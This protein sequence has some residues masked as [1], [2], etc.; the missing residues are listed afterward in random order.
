MPKRKLT[1]KRIAQLAK[2]EAAGAAAREHAAEIGFSHPTGK[3][4]R[5]WPRPGT[6]GAFGVSRSH[7]LGGKQYMT[8]KGRVTF[9]EESEQILRG[10]RGFRDQTQPTWENHYPRP[11]GHRRGVASRS[12]TAERLTM[13]RQ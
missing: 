9:S 1:E 13:D 7:K 2:W 10:E 4:G 5:A 8:K 12:R 11:L 3:R 6:R